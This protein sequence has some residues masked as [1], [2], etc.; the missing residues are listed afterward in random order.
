MRWSV[1]RTIWFREVRDQLRDRRTLF[2]I[3]VLP[4]LLYP[5][6]GM[7]FAQ[8]A[9]LVAER[10]VTV[11]I[12]N[13]ELLEGSAPDTEPRDRH[14]RR[15]PKLI[16]DDGMFAASLYPAHSKERALLKVIIEP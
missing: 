15:L 1:V 3:I 5:G 14:A 13:Y 10:P 8:F 16:D 4:L 9:T 12:A 11:G 6:L 2:M 7:A